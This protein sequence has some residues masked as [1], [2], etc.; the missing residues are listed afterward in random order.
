MD[1]AKEPENV[2]EPGNSFA[3]NT[4][5]TS[6]RAVEPQPQLNMW[7]GEQ[8]A[9]GAL[10]QQ[11]PFYQNPSNDSQ[12]TWKKAGNTQPIFPPPPPITQRDPGFIPP[13]PPSGAGPFDYSQTTTKY[14]PMPPSGAGPFDYQQPVPV[15]SPAP[16]DYQRPIN[17]YQH[18]SPVQQYKDYIKFRITHAS[19]KA[20]RLRLVHNILQ[21]TILLGAAL[22]SISIGFPHSPSW[23][24]PLIGGIVTIATALASYYK[25]GERSRDLYRSAEDMQRDYNWFKSK[26]GVYKN[27]NEIEAFEL[28]QDRIEAFRREDFLRTFSFEEQKEAPK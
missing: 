28:L 24:P 11:P 25:F 12:S 10:S 17:P 7:S 5:P 2:Q 14:S 20:S 6:L 8:T 23:F 13:V 9:Y 26:R 21:I 1:D 15:H 27:L 19:K 16:Y 3:T 4:T 18:H 22:I